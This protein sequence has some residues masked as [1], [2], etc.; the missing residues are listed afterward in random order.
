MEVQDKNPDRDDDRT[1][2]E[3][4]KTYDCTHK[5]V[6]A[7]DHASPARAKWPISRKER[8]ERLRRVAVQKEHKQ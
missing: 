5:R 7:P 6:I 4:K 3:F 8:D 2:Q 1:V